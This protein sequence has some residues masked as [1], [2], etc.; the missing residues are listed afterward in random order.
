MMMM[1]TDHDQEAVLDDQ[2]PEA[3]GLRAGVE[4]Q[5][6]LVAVQG[7]KTTRPMSD[8]IGSTR[9]DLVAAVTSFGVHRKKRMARQRRSSTL[10]L[11][12]LSFA[13]TFTTATRSSSHVPPS[14]LPSARV[15]TFS[16]LLLYFLNFLLTHLSLYI[17]I[18]S[19]GLD[20]YT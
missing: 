15:S 9:D 4:T 11:L 6:G 10:N 1:M 14:T 2:K 3:C 18:I 20:P 7:D 19:A 13:S 17:H 16:F 12:Q 8:Q 5:L